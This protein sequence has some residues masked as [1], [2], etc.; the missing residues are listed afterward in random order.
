MAIQPPRNPELEPGRFSYGSN[1]LGSRRIYFERRFYLENVMPS[2]L[3]G[4]PFASSWTSG[5]YTGRVNTAGNICHPDSSQLKAMWYSEESQEYVYDFVADAWRDFATRLRKLTAENVLFTDSPWAEPRVAQAWTNSEANY[6]YYMNNL[7]FDAFGEG[8]VTLFDNNSR[9]R[10]Y[11]TYLAEFSRF[12]KEVVTK[13]G[14][15]TY[16]GFLESYNTGPLH[17]ALVLEIATDNYADDFIKASRFR[18]ANFGLVAEIAYQYGFQIDR[19]IPWR[20]YADLSSPAM[21]EYMHG[22]PIDQLDLG[23]PPQ[24]CD[25]ELLDPDFDPGAYGYSQV[26][27]MRDVLRRVHVFTEE[28]EIKPG[29][30]KYQS[31]RGASLQHTMETFFSSATKEVWRDDISRLEGYLVSFYNTLV[32]TLPEVSLRQQFNPNDPNQC[33]S[34][35]EIIE[36]NQVTLEEIQ[37]S[38]GDQWRLKT[39]YNLRRHERDIFTSDVV[40]NKANIQ[41]MMNIFY[42]NGRDYTNA[43]EFVQRQFVGPLSPNITAL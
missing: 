18:D 42:T 13:A 16:S 23:N 21:Q 25:P 20:L 10:G 36:R 29:Y 35:P 1:F 32:A 11:Q 31:I 39:F 22:V 7:V 15:L 27:G 19:D 17:S 3:I 30:K 2:N 34:A 26:P 6:D 8:F 40:V 43:L 38:Y 5:L 4:V 14:P 41:R 33:L 37:A 12:I 9:I 24:E 28:D